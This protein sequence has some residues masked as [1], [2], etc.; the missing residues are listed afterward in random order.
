MNRLNES[1]SLYLRQHAEN[2]VHWQPWDES[3]L[4]MARETSTPILLSIGYSACHWCHVM[5]HESFED[6]VT[7]ELMNKLFVNIK[8]DREERPDLDKLYQL[9]H[10]LLSNRGG[11]WP[12]TVFLDPHDLTPF[13]AGTYF[14]PTARHGLPAFKEL[15]EKIREWFD[16]NKDAVKA[17]NQRLSEAIKHL[18]QSTVFEGQPD[19]QIF[20]RAFE[21]ISSR[22]DDVHGG[23][24]GA[25]KFPQAPMLGLL[26]GLS[27]MGR[28]YSSAAHEMLHETLGKMA[29]SGLRDHLDG[30]FFRYTVDGNWTIPHFEKMLYD[31][32]L[33]LPLY[34]QAATRSGDH[35]LVSTTEGIAH[36]LINEMRHDNG[37]F[38]A[39]IDADAD[40]VE[41]GFHVWQPDELN[42]LLSG[43]EYEAIARQ[44]G[45]DGPANFEGHYWHLVCGNAPAELN[46][47]PLNTAKQKML[48]ARLNRIP[49][50]T[51]F[52][53][54]T[55][56]NALCIE[57]FA[58]AGDC[59]QRNDWI[60]AAENALEFIRD[61][62]WVD[63]QLFAVYAEEEARFP[64][65][66]DDH[67]FL[68]K[69]SLSLLRARW[70][71]AVL[72][73]ANELAE[74]M[75]SGFEDPE[76][77][78]FFYSAADQDAPISRLRPL[79]D[80]ATPA[81]NGIA[82]IALEELGHLTADSRYLESAGRALMS[83]YNEI[84]QHPLAFATLV[85]GLDIHLR[86][87]IQV[88]ITGPDARDLNAWKAVTKGFDR[89]NCYLL[90]PGS[91]NLPAIPG[92]NESTEKT[93]AYICE[94]LRCLP[95]LGSSHDLQ[96]QLQ[97][98]Q[99]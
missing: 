29:R 60:D 33:L 85:C 6:P 11:G 48:K 26:L 20:D 1:S 91:G 68:L 43:P 4:T 16:Q 18:Q 42:E 78:G 13:Y 98:L 84:Q 72:G 39:S 38:Y 25:P 40:G 56:W 59:M 17:Q 89:V 82:A 70:N 9:S 95:P 21:Q 61:K 22:Y 63:G 2:P 35:L 28:D 37:G 54:L 99:T 83:S 8:L 44:Y 5:A 74:A 45:L 3:A 50:S 64:A 27:Q 30:G 97:D 10:Q 75:I 49:P 69:A 80:D 36:W 86:P 58:R 73:F 31:N 23:F 24:G 71:P 51:D 76:T 47:G 19:P 67:A 53:Q 93:V 88:I 96:K 79:Q 87:P 57:G 41:G 7:A 90:G 94:G 65:Y 62:L 46:D 77:G 12:L 52:K 92:L 55:S 66:L 81:G 32:A 15:L 14:P 34:A